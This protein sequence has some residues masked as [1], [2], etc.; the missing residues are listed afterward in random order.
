MNDIILYEVPIALCLVALP[1]TGLLPSSLTRIIE[2]SYEIARFIVL[3]TIATALFVISCPIILVMLY[4]L[5]NEGMGTREHRKFMRK[6][7]K[8]EQFWIKSF[9]DFMVPR[10][11]LTWPHFDI[12]LSMGTAIVAVHDRTQGGI[13]L[14][15]VKYVFKLI[16]GGAI[17]SNGQVISKNDFFEQIEDLLSPHSIEPLS[18]K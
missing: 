9:E 8:D 14:D 15:T 11:N 12:T 6:I 1:F 16:D 10:D 7:R 13:K 3:M 17:S 5:A 4:I 18:P 2:I